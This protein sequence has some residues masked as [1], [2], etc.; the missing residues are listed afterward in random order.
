M[1]F[2]AAEIRS[3][4]LSY[5]EKHGHRVV[6]SAALVPHNDPTL[7]FT[8]AGMVQFKDLFTGKEKRDY[9]RA[10]SSQKCVRAG[11]K[12]NDLENVG[13]TARHH[14]FFEMLGNFSFG[15]YFKKDAITLA[16]KFVT[17][18]LGIDK[19]RLCVTVFK[20][21][22]NV[23]ADEE[24]AKLWQDDCGIPKER[25]FR[26]GAKD[27]FWAMGDT[28]PCGPCSEIHFYQGDLSPEAALK[29]FDT[30]AADDQW[31]EIW[32]LVFM[33]FE[34]FADGRLESLPKP[35]IDTGMGLERAAA[36]ANGLKSN[37]ETS[38]LRP[39]I[40]KAAAMC[41]K[42]YTSSQ[43]PDDVSLRVLADHARASAFLIADGVFPSNE[44]RGY[45]LRRIMRRAIR[46]G[47]RLG[48]DDLF[49][50]EITDAVV[51]QM[52]D[53]YP[54][55]RESRTA[56]GKWVRNEEEG[57]RRTLKTGLRLLSQRVE[58]LQAQVLP[59]DDAFEL[60]DT[61]GFPLDLTEVILRERGFTVDQPGFDKALE[62]QRAR[63]G[64]FKNEDKGVAD[65]YKALALKLGPTKFLGYELK[66]SAEQGWHI[67]GAGVEAGYVKCTVKAL[68][69]NGQPVE[70]A[71][72]PV[73]IVL[74]PTPF[75]GESGGQQ[76]D[77]G[78]ELAMSGGKPFAKVKNT[79]K[80][81]E[82]FHVSQI[83]ATVP[84]RVGDTV[85]ARY[86]AH[87]RF[88]TRQHHSAT[89][90]LHKALHDVL[91]DHVKQAGSLV[92]PER[93]RFD[94][95]HFEAL[96]GEQLD[97]IERHVQE[98]IAKKAPIVTE[99]LGFEDAKK[100]GAV[101]LFG[102]KYGDSVRVLTMADSKE[103][104]G[105]TH[106]FNTGDIKALRIVK[107][108]AIA[109]GVRRVEAVVS[110]S[111]KKLDEQRQ[112]QI[113]E[114]W[115]KAGGGGAAPA[116]PVEDHRWLLRVANNFPKA[117]QELVAEAK[118]KRSPATQQV[119]LQLV[120]K[121][122]EDEVAKKQQDQA[123][124]A[125]LG[126]VAQA[127]AKKA[128]DIGGTKLVAEIIEGVSAKD[129]RSYADRVRDH[130][131]SAPHVV[132]LGVVAEGK[133]SVVVAVSKDLTA[134]YKAGD[135]VKT[136]AQAIGGSGGGKPDFAQAGG[137]NVAALPAALN[138]IAASLA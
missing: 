99:V 102:E 64:A 6:K 132:A 66:E 53:V 47:E 46:H 48:F 26:L 129:L 134:K 86:D 95:S 41:K 17:E 52:G 133:A 25:I 97:A 93:L 76:G 38:L 33:Q 112:Q 70:H 19:T 73:D 45:V 30:P 29:I 122:E 94:F 77:R 16:W 63:A 107:E 60:Y 138:G 23:P 80:P 104:C 88:E 85:L 42:N 61:Y 136:V 72:G 24:A 34:R 106:S 96:T 125:Q 2:A 89:H 79:L 118:A 83:D 3:K 105:G 50:H 103:L 81:V 84:V 108:E 28:G 101:A 92:T 127:L 87:D 32:N 9:S 44:G 65:V 69:Q 43:S 15:D 114:L 131:G 54:E 31:I 130:L 109:A 56:I 11:G 123:Q 110:E 116:I 59:G 111:A 55:L 75:Y 117:A 35:S 68:V 10:A 13:V 137:P 135:I 121:R 57:F 126:A 124:S 12:H 7:L 98:R 5:F 49:F 128:K 27:N 58:K 18:E 74:D 90:L 67:E 120:K 20:G 36:V 1:R 119:V 100:A 22:N 62:A 78:G 115:T 21:E 51:Q 91:G 37:Y 82:G 39:L 8:N 14:T 113:A 4:F 71:T 40:D